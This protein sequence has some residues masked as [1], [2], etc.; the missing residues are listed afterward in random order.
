MNE[1]TSFEDSKVKR[2]AHR[3]AWEKYKQAEDGINLLKRRFQVHQVKDDEY[4]SKTIQH[5]NKIKFYE[6]V[7]EEKKKT[8][9]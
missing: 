1:S 2:S 8:K 7:K 3:D 4:R 5:E 6:K 9:L